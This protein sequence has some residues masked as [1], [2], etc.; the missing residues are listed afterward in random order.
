M[1]KIKP[2]LQIKIARPVLKAKVNQEFGNPLNGYLA[3]AY[4]SFGL[5]CRDEDSPLY[6][7][8]FHNGVDFGTPL[9]QKCYAV[10]PCV[11]V[12]VYYGSVSAGN[13]VVCETDEIKEG[14]LVYKLRFRYLHLKAPRVKKGQRLNLGE[15]VGLCGSTGFSSGPHLHF[16]VSLLVKTIA[17]NFM[18]EDNGW[19]GFIN[20]ASLFVDGNWKNMPVDARYDKKRNYILEYTLRF[21]TTPIGALITPFLEKRIEDAKYIHRYLKRRGRTVPLM[22]NR[23]SNAVIYGSWDLE[24]VLNDAMFPVWGWYSKSEYETALKNGIELKTPLRI[25]GSE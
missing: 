4:R 22:T 25:G 20:P 21:A 9:G 12:G 6:K 19:Q 1:Y 15:V 24:T 14:G 10:Y 5:I 16:D 11:V 7:K 23:E 8:P 2:E 17:G 18:R 3:R 13:F